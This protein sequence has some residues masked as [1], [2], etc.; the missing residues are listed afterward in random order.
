[1]TNLIDAS[2]R[3]APG[4]R[5]RTR[6]EGSRTRSEALDLLR[7]TKRVAMADRSLFAIR[8]GEAAA[9][10]DPQ[11][12]EH[13]AR[14]WLEQAWP[15][16]DRWAKRKRLIC[17]PGEEPR[18]PHDDGSYVASGA[19]WAALIDQAARTAHPGDHVTSVQERARFARDMLRGS[20][21]LPALNIAP[22]GDDDAQY[23][24]F[25]MAA[26]IAEKIEQE[27]DL[28]RL[29]EKVGK[30]PFDIHSYHLEEPEHFNELPAWLR[31][32]AQDDYAT[33]PLGDA[34]LLAQDIADFRYRKTLTASN[35]HRR[36]ILTGLI[37]W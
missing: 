33:G 8:L 9:R 17:F 35:R 18:N 15:A 5:T 7:Q 14:R 36:P 13:I 19:D 24:V 4:E 25:R 10:I 28:P 27:T 21:F 11:H 26:M 34:A 6:G 30:V 2:D 12:P 3:F 16:S 31:K 29:W 20:A 22:L 1:M 37:L 23:H 32:H